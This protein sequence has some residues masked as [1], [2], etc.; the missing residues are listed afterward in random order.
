MTTVDIYVD[1]E[2]ERQFSL[3]N[4]LYGPATTAFHRLTDHIRGGEV[5]GTYDGASAKGE[6][7]G[8]VLRLLLHGVGED[9]RSYDPV[10]EQA[11][12]AAIV[13]DYIYDVDAIEF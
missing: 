3:H 13:D 8:T 2:G 4:G 1:H 10:D 11:L 7:P 12:L 6:V 9:T 5:R